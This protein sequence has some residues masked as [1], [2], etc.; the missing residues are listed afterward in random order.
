MNL[1]PDMTAASLKM[2]VG[3]AVVLLALLVFRYLVRRVTRRYEGPFPGGRIRVLASRC[4][5]V[6]KSI[7]LVQVPG[8]VLVLGVTQDRITCLTQIS[9]KALLEPGDDVEPSHPV[10]AFFSQLRDEMAAPRKKRA[11]DPTA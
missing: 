2:L 3:L 4:I 8:T 6:K 9:E 1:A 5:G 7:S 11:V 10:T